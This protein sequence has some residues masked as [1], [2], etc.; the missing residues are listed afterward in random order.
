MRG[1]F[2]LSA[3][4][5]IGPENTGGRDVARIVEQAVAAGFTFVQI[6]SK[7]ASAREMIELLRRSA[8]AIARL[9]KSRE[10]ALVADDRLDVVLAARAEGIKVDGV[11]VG[12]SDVPPSV[13]RRYL[14]DDAVIGLSSLGDDDLSD[15][16]YLGIGPLRET[17]TKKDCGLK[18][19]R[20]HTLSLERMAE[21]ASGPLPVVVGGGVKLGDL[22][23]IAATGAHGFFVVSAVAGSDDPSRA[24]AELVQEWRA[25]RAR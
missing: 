18:D 24:A 13:C 11:H 12:R 3:Y 21:L 19:G 7:T 1:R 9:G 15:V 5:V 17:Q 20:V 8:D 16:D 6:R 4:L 22:R 2:D 25:A 14:G 23:G 10:V